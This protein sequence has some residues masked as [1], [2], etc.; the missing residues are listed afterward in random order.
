M[1]ALQLD[2]LRWGQQ[3][4]TNS[5]FL[6]LW[7]LKHLPLLPLLLNLI[8]YADQQTVSRCKRHRSMEW[9]FSMWSS[10]YGSRQAGGHTVRVF[11]TSAPADTQHDCKGMMLSRRAAHEANQQCSSVTLDVLLHLGVP[12]KQQVAQH[13]VALA[14]LSS[15][16]STSPQM[17]WATRIEQHLSQ[18]WSKV[19]ASLQQCRL[20]RITTPLLLWPV[21]CRLP[22]TIKLLC[23]G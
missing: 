23:S 4:N 6:L 16:S 1:Q 22:Q 12:L 13:V 2:L 7:L 18:S 3:R 21:L 10:A 14:C 5:C 8:H 9:R 19:N 11:C 20:V 15:A 17:C